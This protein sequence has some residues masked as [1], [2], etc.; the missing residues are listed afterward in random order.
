MTRHVRD[1]P[2]QLAGRGVIGGQEGPQAST[3][4]VVLAA[5]PLE[6]RAFASVGKVEGREEL[7]DEALRWKRQL[8]ALRNVAPHSMTD[9]PYPTQ[10]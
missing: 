3:Q 9:D 6:R 1:R 7:D 10:S 2:L 4:L 8:A 5:L